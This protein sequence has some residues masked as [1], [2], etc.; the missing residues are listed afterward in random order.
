M[1]VSIGKSQF[2][3]K[4]AA[5]PS[6]SYTIRALMCAALAHGESE[7]RYPLRSDD[8][9]AAVNALEK[10]GVRVVARPDAL[11]VWGG[12]LITPESAL[13]CGESA[14]TLRFLTAITAIIPGECRLH[15]K[16]T[17]VARP[18]DPLLDALR[19]IGVECHREAK[20]GSITIQ[21]GNIN[22]DVTSL[23]GDISSQYVSALLMLAPLLKRG[24]NIRLTTPLESRGYVEMTIECLNQ[25]GIK[26]VA[27]PSFNSFFVS[28]QKYQPTKY[29][30]EGDWSSVSYLLA[31]GALNGS[32]EISNLDSAS[33][34]GDKILLN[35][36]H[37]MGATVGL[38]RTTF[39]VS[40]PANE[41]RP[42]KV[43]LKESIDLLPTMMVL[44]AF[45][46]GKS[47]FHGIARARLKESDRVKTMQEE[48]EKTGVKVESRDDIVYVQGTTPKG[49]IFESHNDHRI[50]MALSLIGICCG[51]T[52]I[53]G[54]ECVSKT[55]PEYWDTI[56]NLGVELSVR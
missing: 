16:P 52:T 34:Q 27:L 28:S 42:I 14:A 18:I 9:D 39:R 40:K 11:R 12:R 1:Q 3:G 19:Q 5:P 30:I 36:L 37:E 35:F 50:A 49:A 45:A 20:N 7:L 41:L 26:V 25:F 10:I 13:E 21:G 15:A 47:E 43:D 48:L 8:T 46:K 32:V 44:A 23:P 4:T 51:E 6:K 29:T 56:K 53:K 24:L 17:L 22:K 31:A 2:S 38:D 54:A 55:Y 33:L